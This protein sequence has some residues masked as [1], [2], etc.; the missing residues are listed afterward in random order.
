MKTEYQM[1]LAT[2]VF[3]L[4]CKG[5]TVKEISDHLKYVE[6]WTVGASTRNI[7]NILKTQYYLRLVEALQLEQLKAIESLTDE[8]TKI[9]WRQKLLETIT[10]KTVHT[11]VEE[12]T[13]MQVLLD[14]LGAKNPKHYT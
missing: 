12:G 5:K 13:D 9:R 14:G 3:E 1:A 2:K 10:P 4:R 6:G 8:V 11:H 7:Y